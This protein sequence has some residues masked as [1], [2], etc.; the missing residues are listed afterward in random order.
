MAEELR[1][2][3]GRG[4]YEVREILDGDA[5]LDMAILFR[6]DDYAQ[7]VEFALDYL[8]RRDPRR[9]GAVGG[10]QVLK[11][12]DGRRETAWTYS[13]TAEANRPDPV[14][15]WGF[16]VTKRWSA[17]IGPVVRPTPLRTRIARRV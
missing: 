6:C 9:T 16:D 4:R 13:P 12:E 1:H 14:S 2:A 15:V 3:A 11:E 17:P 10:L 5:G 7:A 8:G